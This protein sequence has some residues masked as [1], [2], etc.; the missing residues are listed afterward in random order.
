MILTA[1]SVELA[2]VA[3]TL[4]PYFFSK[5]ALTGRTSWLM[6]WVVYQTTSPSFLAAS[7][8]AAS[9][10][11]AQEPARLRTAAIVQCRY[12][13]AFLPMARGLPAFRR[14]ARNASPRSRRL[15][16]RE[17]RQCKAA[18]VGV[19]QHLDRGHDLRREQPDVLFRE[20]RRQG[21]ELQHADQLLK[22][23]AMMAFGDAAAHRVGTAADHDPAL[24]QLLDLDATLVSTLGRERALERFRRHVAGRKEHQL[25]LLGQ[26]DVEQRLDVLA[27]LVHGLLVALGDVD[28]RG[29][30]DAIG[31][32]LVAVTALRDFTIEVQ[33]ACDRFDRAVGLQIDVFAVGMGGPF[34]RLDASHRWT[35]DRR[36]RLLERP[37]PHVH[38]FAVIVLALEGEGAGLGPCPH[39]EVVRLLVALE[40]VHG[41]RAER[42]IF[43]ADA[44]HETADQAPTGDDIEHGMLFGQCERMLAQAERIAQD[45]DAAVARAPRQRRGH[46]NRRGHEPVGVLVMLVHAYAVEAELGAELELVEITVVER[47]PLL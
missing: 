33:V 3:R 38:V 7:T 5:A 25:G 8:K 11:C 24:D 12:A 45:G 40:R 44:A 19:G 10:A 42:E 37:R 32:R 21:A 6:I 4:M 31:G 34:E 43:R 20:P 28:R 9:A 14:L 27:R 26:E 41:V 1:S 15:F 47:V 46:H 22:A 23:H 2:R 30:A 29:P 16:G 39:D 13:I 18:I 17:A 35:P 36:M